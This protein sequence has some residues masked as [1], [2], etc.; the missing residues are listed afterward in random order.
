V[1]EYFAGNTFD[2][3]RSPR[4]FIAATLAWLLAEKPDFGMR[5][6]SRHRR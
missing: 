1:L 2:P 3:V 4:M 6:Q 5:R